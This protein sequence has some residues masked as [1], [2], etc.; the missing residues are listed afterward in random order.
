L[1]R[2]KSLRR[3]SHWLTAPLIAWLAMNVSFLAWHVPRAYDFAL[4]HEGWHDVEHLCFLG[5]SILFW[6]CILRPWPAESSRRASSSWGIL[7]FLV[8][9]DIVNTLLSASLA[10]C[11]RPVYSF[12][13][14]QPNLFHVSPMEDQVLGAVIMWVVGS[15][16]F[17]V[18]A[19][20]ITFR[21]LQPRNLVSSTV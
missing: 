16:A 13:L 7:L 8:S 18:P 6:H 14:D 17:L 1:I 20:V 5:T 9:A 19:I 4:E 2:L 11:G 3:L 10:F 21:L 12:Y 15:L